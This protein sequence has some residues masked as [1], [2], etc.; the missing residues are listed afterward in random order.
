MS[1]CQELH[2]PQFGDTSK[3][4]VA[5]HWELSDCVHL[6]FL[7]ICSW[8]CNLNSNYIFPCWKPPELCEPLHCLKSKVWNFIFIGTKKAGD[9]SPGTGRYSVLSLTFQ[10]AGSIGIQLHNHPGVTFLIEIFNLSA[11][12]DIIFYWMQKRWLFYIFWIKV[13]RLKNK[14]ESET[15]KE[16]WKLMQLSCCFQQPQEGS[17]IKMTFPYNWHFLAG[18]V[19]W[20]AAACVQRPSWRGSLVF[21]IHQMGFN[22]SPCP[23]TPHLPPR[24]GTSS[25]LCL[26]FT[27]CRGDLF[28]T[29]W[30][31]SSLWS[32]VATRTC[33]LLERWMGT[34][35]L[36]ISASSFG[37]EGFFCSFLFISRFTLCI[38]VYSSSW[39][40]LL[41]STTRTPG[42]ARFCGFHGLQAHNW[43]PASYTQ[44][45]HGWYFL[46]VTGCCGTEQLVFQIVEIFPKCM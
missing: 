12:I 31:F 35:A 24:T 23:H 21:H 17:G 40:K 22:F 15:E 4:V 26:F 38:C 7:L 3:S 41:Y 8:S 46:L 37:S 11:V 45:L 44:V 32:L 42:R 29:S 36:V 19:F 30:F 33:F 28:H 34:M 2:C 6:V 18:A 25:E 1:R 10:I 20:F 43:L 16:G 5:P 9:V 27:F 13:K 14:R 39:Q